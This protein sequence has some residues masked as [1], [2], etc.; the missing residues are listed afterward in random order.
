[1]DRCLLN[2]GFTDSIL[3]PSVA[4][5]AFLYNVFQRLK[6]SYSSSVNKSLS[7]IRRQ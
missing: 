1:M 4:C 7:N 6:L 3:R 5:G 2:R